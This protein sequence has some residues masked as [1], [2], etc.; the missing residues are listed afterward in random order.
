VVHPCSFSTQEAEA[1]GSWVWGQPGLYSET[2]SKKHTI[3]LSVSLCLSVSL[4]L[5]RAH[6]YTH[7]HTQSYIGLIFLYIYEPSNYWRDSGIYILSL[8]L[9][10]LSKLAPKL[11]MVL[12][13]RCSF[14]VH[15]QVRKQSVM[16]SC[17][18]TKHSDFRN[19]QM[20]KGSHEILLTRA[21]LA[22]F[23]CW[24]HMGR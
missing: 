22:L 10:I 24:F 15:N 19:V 18:C 20:S 5:S 17:H 13:V 3:S 23:I 7:T 9:H 8:S 1:G 6:T 11:K 2:L 4:S 16:L 14:N 12:F 21:E